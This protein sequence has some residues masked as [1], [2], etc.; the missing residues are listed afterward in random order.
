M[1]DTY[2]REPCS[3]FSHAENYVGKCRMKGQNKVV[4]TV[5]IQ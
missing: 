3:L 4:A 2:N 5:M 1:I